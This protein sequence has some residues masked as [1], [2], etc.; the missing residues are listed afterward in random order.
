MENL[1]RICLFG[2]PQISLG[3][4]R[5]KD[6]PTEKVKLL[7]CYLVLFQRVPHT[8]HVLAGLLWGNCT[9]L[10]A[11]H[12][13]STA[14]WRLRQWLSDLPVKPSAYLSIEDKQIVFKTPSASWL[15]VAEFEERIR[16]AR[17]AGAA[18]PN[19]ASALHRAVELYRG[20][21]LEGCYADWCLAERNRLHELYLHALLQLMVHCSA[22]RDYPQ[23]I[24][25][26]Q[27]ILDDDPLRE[28]IHREVIKLFVLNHQPVEA[29]RQYQ[30]CQTALREELGIE[31]MPETQALFQQLISASA[32]MPVS[33]PFAT[34]D[35]HDFG[36]Q[37]KLLL[38]RI[39][40]M[41]KHME[42]TR[43]DLSLAIEA[44]KQIN[45]DA[46]R[47]SNRT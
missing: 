13:L 24:T 38:Q 11:R 44:L 41:L 21:L 25:F 5:V 45:V 28:E 15:D 17:Q 46:S 30:R 19:S 40:V 10:N 12:S 31:P 35:L 23:A 29:L 1:L 39:D 37:L 16:S 4:S 43:D 18:S 6:F 33:I 36:G 20:E 8:R 2:P 27:R 47:E 42:R 22:K 9:E 32:G 14:I 7:F 26:G 3:G 34:S